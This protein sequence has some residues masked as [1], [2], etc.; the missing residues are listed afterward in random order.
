[1]ETTTF[2]HAPSPL[3][4][5]EK[6]A[7]RPDEGV[8]E[9]AIVRTKPPHHAVSPNSLAA[10]LRHFTGCKHA[11]ELEEKGTLLVGSNQNKAY[12]KDEHAACVSFAQ[13]RC[14]LQYCLFDS[15]YLYPLNYACVCPDLKS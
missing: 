5:G 12:C 1:M 11:N 8:V 2:E 7:D 6:V 9:P 13:A 10:T 15:S 4:S 3:S 14:T